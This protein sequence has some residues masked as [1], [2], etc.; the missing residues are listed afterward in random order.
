MRI[1]ERKDRRQRRADGHRE[2]RLEHL[3]RRAELAPHFAATGIATLPK[4]TKIFQGRPNERAARMTHVW[5]QVPSSRDDKPSNAPLRL[6]SR[7]CLNQ[8]ASN[9]IE[10]QPPA[11]VP[12]SADRHTEGTRFPPLD[13]AG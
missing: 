2:A 9:R 6:Q 8:P 13:E 11:R 5:L 4:T 7:T 3:E 10:S 12:R 1:G